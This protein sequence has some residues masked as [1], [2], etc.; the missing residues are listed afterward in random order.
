MVGV[1]TEFVGVGTELVG[2][3]TEFVGVGTEFVGGGVT[4]VNGVDLPDA[5]NATLVLGLE[6]VSGKVWFDD[7]QLT[8]AKAPITAQP[9]PVAGPVF[10]GHSLP[11]LRGAMVSPGID[12]ESLRVLLHPA[13]FS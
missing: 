8:V 3:G 12:S 1:G 10:K 2:V 13:L 9:T 7:L 11:R 6:Q 5:T 4:T